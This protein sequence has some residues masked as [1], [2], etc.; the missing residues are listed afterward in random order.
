MRI[1]H[2]I[3]SVNLERGGPIE[4][5]R[6]MCEAHE[7]QGHSCAFVTLDRPDASWLR[8]FPFSVHA[9]GAA[10]CI[11]NWRSFSRRVAELA[12]E[13]DVAVVHGLWN[14]A[15]VAGY[16]GLSASGLPWVIF[17]H[18]M[19]DPYFARLNPA[20]DRLKQLAWT[21][22][23]GRMMSHARAVLFTCE[24][25][26]R[27][28]R[29]AFRGHQGYTARIVAFCASD[30]SCG[31]GEL[32]EGRAEL[33]RR[34]PD[35]GDQPYFLFLS[36]IHPKKACDDLIKAYAMIAP[37]AGSPELVFAGPD[38]TGW[39]P[40]LERL[41]QQLGVANRVHWAGMIEGPVKS[42]AYT[43]AEAFALPSHQE[44]FGL[45]VAEA[46]SVGTPV[47][48][49]DRVNIWREV[50]ADG[51]GLA[52]PDTVGATARVLERYLSMDPGERAAM[53]AAARPCY[54]RQ[55]SV[56]AAAA[57][58]LVVLSEASRD[59]SQRAP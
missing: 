21:S 55:F 1:L 26:R 8:G 49:S 56:E 59:S 27:L 23:Q 34:L 19:L 53:Q 14:V 29:G 31:E 54:E 9:A 43:G 39:K 57:D 58:L 15:T 5:A 28:A 48:I 45:V 33:A 2:L 46:L 35:L 12:P 50:V 44:N 38:Q 36:R 25:E 47:L 22:V 52:A 51:A 37:C 18:G 4:Y 20:K 10:G 7:A 32:A 13:F 3:D 16:R 6:V 41:A 42:A 30:Q 24:E 11:A 40:E 17:T